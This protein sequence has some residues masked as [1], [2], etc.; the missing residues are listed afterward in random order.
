[1]EDGNAP[2]S[3]PVR[4]AADPLV[5]LPTLLHDLGNP[6]TAITTNVEFLRDLVGDL[7]N[8]PASQVELMREVLNEIGQSATRMREITRDLRELTA[9]ASESRLASNDRPDL[10]KAQPRDTREGPRIRNASGSE[11]K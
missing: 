2:P 1:M 5:R 3:E 7:S 4:P 9:P 8:L 6:L 10:V 11:I